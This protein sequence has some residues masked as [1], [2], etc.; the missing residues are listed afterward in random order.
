MPAALGEYRLQPKGA[1]SL[2]R[3]Y[4]PASAEAFGK[5]LAARGASEK[6]WQALVRW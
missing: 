1:T 6:E 5:E 4:V 2:L 3:T